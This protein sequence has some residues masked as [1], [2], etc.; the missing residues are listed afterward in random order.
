VHIRRKNNFTVLVLPTISGHTDVGEGYEADPLIIVLWSDEVGWNVEVGQSL[1]KQIVPTA[2]GTG[3]KIQN[4][5]PV[6]NIVV[7]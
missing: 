7:N 1:I 4:I 2:G 5:S 3:V 6:G